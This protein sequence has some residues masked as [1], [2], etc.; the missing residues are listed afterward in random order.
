MGKGLAKDLPSPVIELPKN[1]KQIEKIKSDYL[2]LLQK[3]NKTYC[4]HS[5]QT[6]FDQLSTK[7]KSLNTYVPELSDGS[8]DVETIKNGM[9]ELES[10]L[11]WINQTLNRLKDQK[12]WTNLAKH[13]EP[14]EITAS[15]LLK[16]KEKRFLQGDESEG[17]EDES[18]ALL[19]KLK[20]QFE[21]MMN[22]LYFLSNY[23]YPNNHLDQRRIFDDN[24]TEKVK[25]QTKL[26]NKVMFQRKLRED[27]AYD[28]GHKNSDFFLRAA[29]NTLSIRLGVD[30]PWLSEDNRYDLEWA[31]R[32]IRKYLRQGKK[33]QIL[34]FK[35]W[36]KSQTET[37]QFYVGILD[38]KNQAERKLFLEK[39]KA[40]T[41][42]REFVYS[43]NAKVYKELLNTTERTQAIYVLDQI[44]LHEVGNATNDNWRDRKDVAQVVLNSRADSDLSII[45]KNEGF[46]SYLQAEGVPDEVMKSPSWLNVMFKQLRFSFTLYYIPAVR[47][48][49]CP[50]FYKTAVSTRNKNLNL[51]VEILRE[52]Q[53]T[54]K[55]VR[56]F[57]RESMV[58]RI[59]MGEVWGGF[60]QVPERVGSRFEK[61]SGLKKAIRKNKYRYLY[62]FKDPEGVD[63]HVLEIGHKNYAM[64][65]SLE[66]PDFFAYRNPHKFRFFISD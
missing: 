27:G 1:V 49:A 41:H 50:D 29:L 33:R 17:V 48:I 52:P 6:E 7:H 11:S 45:K 58:G 34:R 56:Y 35:E 16:L 21:V 3:I 57:S 38:E 51:I 47:H 37:R 53:T 2:Q 42:L 26:A 40:S 13:I 64:K 60:K 12:K 55:A 54:F 23:A 8:I 39:Q 61:D 15:Q 19:K 22:E 46:Y 59:D 24:R 31:I 9:P 30:G 10:K 65:G 20:N 66:K 18:R 28:P 63:Y 44:L 43:S 14:L 4:T 36:L 62:S 5:V 25:E 32:E